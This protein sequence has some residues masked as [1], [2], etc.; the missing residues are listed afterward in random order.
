M[1][2]KMI[3]ITLGAGIVGFAGMFAVAWFTKPAAPIPPVA[4]ADSVSTD[5]KTSEKDMAAEIAREAAFQGQARQTMTDQQL[6]SLVFE[7]RQKIK[8]YDDKLRNLDVREQRLQAA[9]LTLEKDI[10]EMTT[11]R[12]ELASAVASLRT[13]QDKLS[14]SKVEIEKTETENLISIAATY[15]KMDAESAA[16]ILMN[17]VKNQNSNTASDDA[18]KILYYMTD[19]T[20][21]KVLASLADTEPPVSAYICQ[22][23]KKLMTKE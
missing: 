3:F 15:D 23:L 5:A 17:M 8:E 22:R 10:E 18:V 7:V 4:Q 12:L 2:K 13:E 20:K 6:E 1:K 14:K 19:R 21:A 16:K 9:R 11:L